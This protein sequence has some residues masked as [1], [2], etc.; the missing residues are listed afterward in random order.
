MPREISVRQRSGTGA[1]VGD[2]HLSTGDDQ[3]IDDRC[4]L[5]IGH[6]ANTL[7]DGD[8]VIDVRAACL[9][10]YGDANPEHA[11]E[12]IVS[13]QRHGLFID[14]NTNLATV[15]VIVDHLCCSI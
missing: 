7:A 2:S 4:G 14:L 15:D 5:A 9:A 8:V 11:S 10:R 1:G 12:A 3:P 6:H 13:D